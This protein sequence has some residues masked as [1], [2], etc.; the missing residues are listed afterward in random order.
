M[1]GM[2]IN[3]RDLALCAKVREAMVRVDETAARKR[4]QRRCEIPTQK[5]VV[6]L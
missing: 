1:D 4:R 2:A 6:N 5:S 3:E